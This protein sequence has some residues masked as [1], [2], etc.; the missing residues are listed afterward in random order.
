[1]GNFMKGYQDNPKLSHYD[2]QP[3][4]REKLIPIVKE[5]M[6]LNM[7]LYWISRIK[8]WLEQGLQKT[9]FMINPIDEREHTGTLLVCGRS[10]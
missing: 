7:W 2:Q 5:A 1:M 6:R 3:A 8:Q 10:F 9:Y 4:D